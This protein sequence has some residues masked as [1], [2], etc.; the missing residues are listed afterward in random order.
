MSETLTI[1]LGFTLPCLMT[2]LG[3]SLV[4]FFKKTSKIFRIVNAHD[5]RFFFEKREFSES[6]LLGFTQTN[7][8][9]SNF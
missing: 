7:E 6:I 3:A 2:T 8:T 5:A 1:I 4:F 9:S